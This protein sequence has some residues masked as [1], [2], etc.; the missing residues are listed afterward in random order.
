M[1]AV[2]WAVCAVLSVVVAR[3]SAGQQGG[4]WRT[5][6]ESRFPTVVAYDTTRV[7]KVA[8]GRVDVVERYTLHP[9]R[10]DP[11]GI[12]GS[13]VMGV[14]VDCSAQETALRSVARYSPS[15]KLLSPEQQFGT[16]EDS[17]SEEGAGSLE[18]SALHGLCAALHLAPPSAAGPR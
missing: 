16:G 15:G 8:H 10:H 4:P 14:I 5:I 9:P 1:R 2:T 7:R 13:I 18:A 11:D 3:A 6:S 12:V 17:F